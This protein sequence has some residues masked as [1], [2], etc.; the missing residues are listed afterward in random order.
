M[1]NR[2]GMSPAVGPL[3]VGTDSEDF[4]G[5]VVAPTR[6]VSEELASLVDR[7]TRRIVEEAQAEALDLLRRERQRLE[8]LAEALLREETLDE[9]QIR[10]VT[11]LEPAPRQAAPVAAERLPVPTKTQQHEAAQSA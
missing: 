9:A 1:V 4:L 6:E 11:G 7:E 8:V 5:Q 3:F 10:R 2:W